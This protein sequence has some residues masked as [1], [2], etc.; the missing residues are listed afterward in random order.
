MRASHELSTTLIALQSHTL[1][2]TDIV[3]KQQQNSIYH[4][5]DDIGS[6]LQADC[7]PHVAFPMSVA[8]LFSCP[9]PRCLCITIF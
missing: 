7:W 6:S 1:K 4:I 2:V 9:L 8:Y 5:A 3:A